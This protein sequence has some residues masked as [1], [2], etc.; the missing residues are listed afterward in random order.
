MSVPGNTVSH[1]SIQEASRSRN[2]P[3]FKYDALPKSQHIRVLKLEPGVWDSP[4]RCSLKPCNIGNDTLSYEAISYVWG[5]SSER[6]EITCDG[7]HFLVTTGLFDALQT[8]R[9]LYQ[10]RTLWAD[11]ICINQEDTEERNHQ[12]QLM[13]II[14]SKAT[15]VLIWLGHEDPSIVQSGLDAVCRIVNEVFS[16]TKRD[17]VLADYTWNDQG[18]RSFN[19]SILPKPAEAE[20]MKA[21]GPLFACTWFTRLWVIQEVVLSSAVVI[22]WGNTVID[23]RWLGLLADHLQSSAISPVFRL[24]NHYNSIYGRINCYFIHRLQDSSQER[25][26]YNLMMVT[27]G[28]DVSDPRDRIFG[29]LGLH[30]NDSNLDDGNLFLE[31]NYNLSLSEVLED[32]TTK[33]LFDKQEV[34]VFSRV[35]HG[36][37]IPDD[38]TSWMP[39]W[40]ERP[41]SMLGEQAR[42]TKGDTVPSICRPI[43]NFAN[44]L[45]IKGTAVENILAVMSNELHRF[46]LI[47]ITSARSFKTLSERLREEY[48][49]ETVACTLTVGRSSNSD[50]IH[51]HNVHL[52]EF[53]AFLA[54][55]LEQLQLVDRESIPASSGF[56][57]SE[58][59]SAINFLE[60]INFAMFYRRLFTTTKGHLGLG[61]ESMQEGDIVTVLFG[62]NVP[63]ILRPVGDDHY[64]LVGECYFHPVMEGQAIEEWKRAASQQKSFTSIEAKTQHL[65]RTYSF[66]EEPR[67][68]DKQF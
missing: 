20:E 1:D 19:R 30:T 11:A 18:P 25:S 45:A 56:K 40:T 12:V 6:K 10:P 68:T 4:I 61:P 46:S 38:R 65:R 52:A 9:Q 51:D 54:W 17:G 48:D 50:V 44:C 36:P 67:S 66:E 13:R 31:P 55:N 64:R 32:V 39:D 53:N 29:L 63:Y 2:V 35:R 16:E 22:Y 26:F 47:E 43:C 24:H 8:F 57:D 62:G 60:A 15:K 33:M 34:T 42:K 14:Y 21:L 41:F 28:F 23:F 37:F 49:A 58:T 3:Q 5:T 7:Q 27:E 59:V